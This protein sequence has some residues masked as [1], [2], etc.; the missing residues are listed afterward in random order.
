[1]ARVITGIK[2]AAD[3]KL[4]LMSERLSKNVRFVPIADSCS[5][6]IGIAIHSPRQRAQTASAVHTNAWIYLVVIVFRSE[7]G[8]LM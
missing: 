1:L 2:V 6:A 4:P 8:E 5:A 3:G 7:I